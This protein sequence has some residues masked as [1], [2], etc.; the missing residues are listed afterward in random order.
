MREGFLTNFPGVTF[1]ADHVTCRVYGLCAALS[2][3]SAYIAVVQS[4]THL[5]DVRD[6]R[7]QPRL[8]CMLS[9]NQQVV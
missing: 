2:A 8:W 4:E 6:T 5:Q 9:L 1:E 7:Q 3:C